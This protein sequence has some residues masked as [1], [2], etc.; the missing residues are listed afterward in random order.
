MILSCITFYLPVVDLVNMKSALFYLID[1]K[2]VYLITTKGNVFDSTAWGL[3]SVA[4]VIPTMALF[5]IF[6]YKNRVK[7][8]RLCVVNMVFMLMYYVIL[9]VN[10]WFISSR[11]NAEWHLH[12]VAGFPLISMV[13][14]YLAIGAIGKDEKLVKSADRIR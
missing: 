4:A 10:V 11:L 6:Q 3:T 9:F 2:G 7:Q 1:F 13:L 12:L 5:C 14:N 8:I